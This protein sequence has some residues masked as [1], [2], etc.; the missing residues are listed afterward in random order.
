MVGSLDARNRRRGELVGQIR[1]SCLRKCHHED[2]VRP[3]V[4][5]ANAARVAGP[6]LLFGFRLWAS[7]CL[8]LFVASWLEL[9][10]PYWAGASAAIVCQPYRGAS[11]RKSCYRIISSS[12]LR[13]KD[14]TGS[15]ALVADEN[16][17][18]CTAAKPR[19]PYNV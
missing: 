16:S 8:A 4:T 10:N 19:P 7:V 15:E 12:Q 2:S 18:S 5:L 6:P 3:R 17:V 1:R 14:R 13:Y 9:D 11:Q